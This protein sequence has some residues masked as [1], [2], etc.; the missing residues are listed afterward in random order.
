[1]KKYNKEKLVKTGHYFESQNSFCLNY[2]YQQKTVFFWSPY[3]LLFCLD[4]HISWTQ[5]ANTSYTAKLMTLLPAKCK[6][7]PCQLRCFRPIV[8]LKLDKPIFKVGFIL[9]VR[10]LGSYMYLMHNLWKSRHLKFTFATYDF[11]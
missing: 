7:K 5:R 4:R 1:M 11:K 9:S 8:L 2:L 6:V 10:T 3:L